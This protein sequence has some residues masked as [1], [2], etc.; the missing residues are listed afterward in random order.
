MTTGTT[1]TKGQALTSRGTK[2]AAVAAIRNAAHFLGDYWVQTNHQATR[3]VKDE[4]GARAACLRHV[5][6]YS[7]TNAAA[8][9]L[10]NR[11]L[12]LGLSWR[13]IVA[14]ELL[15][16]I[17]HY[18]AD[19]RDHGVLPVIAEWTGSGKFYTN[20]G[21][22]GAALLDQAWHHVWN[23]AAALLTAAAGDR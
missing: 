20:D 18:A 1:T 5:A 11:V 19:R 9:L 16:A 8:V 21:E 7:A 10:A 3:K 13:G 23:A 4:P 14:G 2:F 6:T 17:T 12:G 15:S 22:H